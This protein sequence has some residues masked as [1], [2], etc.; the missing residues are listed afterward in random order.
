MADEEQRADEGRAPGE[1]S[2]RRA[3]LFPEVPDHE[4]LRLIGKGAYGEVWLARSLTGTYRA[5]KVVWRRDYKDEATYVRE[6]E[7]IL[8]YEPVARGIPGVV[9]I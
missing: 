4:I 8:Q 3:G 7:S 1:S 9:H 6:F 2:R 5:V